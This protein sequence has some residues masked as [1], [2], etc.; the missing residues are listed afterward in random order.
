MKLKYIIPC[1]M[2]VVA[3]AC[4]TDIESESGTG[5]KFGEYSLSGKVEKGPFVRGS[6]ISIQPVNGS[7]S[8]E[9]TVFNGEIKDDAGSFD[10][11]TVELASQFVRLS[12]DGYYFNEVTGELSQSQLHLIAYADLSDVQTVNVNIL[13]HLKSGRIQALMQSGKTFAEANTQA[14]KE[15]LTQF[16]LQAHADIS[17]ESMSITSGNDGAGVLIAISSLVLRERS[18]AEITQYISNLTQDL[19]DDGSFNEQNAATMASD[20]KELLQRLDDISDNIVKRY[21]SLGQNI[22]VPN[23]K[24]YFDWDGDGIAGNESAQDAKVTLSQTDVNFGKEGGTATIAVTSNVKVSTTPRE[25]QADEVICPKYVEI[26]NQGRA[27]QCE[28]TLDG[29]TLTIKVDPTERNVSQ[30]HAVNLYDYFDN[31]LASVTVT[32]EGDPSKKPTLTEEGKQIVNES[33][34]NFR[35]ALS[36]MYYVERGYTGTYRFRNV[37]CP[38]Y[39]DNVYNNSAFTAAYTAVSNNTNVLGYLSGYSS[40]EAICRYPFFTVLNAIVYTEMADKWGN[41]GIC[42][43]QASIS[44]TYQLPQ[45][46]VL[47]FISNQLD[48]VEPMCPDTKA[49]A[50]PSTLDEAFT[51]SKD[52]WRIAKANVLMMMGQY[53]YAAFFLQPIA[54]SGRYTLSNGAEYSL[55][56]GTI[57]YFD[58]PTEVVNNNHTVGYYNYADVLL[59][60]AECKLAMG[61]TSSAKTFVDKVASAKGKS[62]SGEVLKD[63][64]DLR[65]ALFLPRYFAFQK[66]HNLGDYEPYQRLWP[67]PAEELLKSGWTQNP[68]Y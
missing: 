52:V 54:D 10:V 47:T 21:E 46:Q 63:I 68:G 15:L 36:W 57:L 28:A 45:S 53:D 26:L 51:I 17:A 32:L 38:L 62:L 16:G 49:I 7:L 12:A 42:G 3:I 20:R 48:K 19:A 55:N 6:A 41:I 23:L 64:N 30:T 44:T 31:V 11:G 50:N 5:T 58:V 35:T 39:E 60:L 67:I 66:R 13:T 8:P 9:G 61:N 43:V 25:S 40:D 14:H 65:F 22:T 29:E 34:A 24:M 1:L 56:S 18:E 27:I 59:S 4:S 37:K 33:L 2:S